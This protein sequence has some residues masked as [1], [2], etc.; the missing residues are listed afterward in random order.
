M[1]NKI[2]LLLV[3]VLLTGCNRIEGTSSYIRGANLTEDQK[4]IVKL[5]GEQIYIF[6]YQLKEEY[7]RL[8]TWWE[9]YKKGEYIGKQ[10]DMSSIINGKKGYIAEVRNN[11]SWQISH[12]TGDSVA[13]M[14]A[15]NLDVI[16]G[17]ETSGKAT[18]TLNDSVT[19]S[20][21]QEIVLM[22]LMMSEDGRMSVYDPHYYVENPEVIEEYD[23][24]YLLKCAFSNKGMRED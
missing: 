4:E 2:I 20:K 22:V 23:Y 12:K 21:D 18:S 17:H 3:I 14:I 6:E 24:I 5:I 15:D 11:K 9:L 10:L 13:R 7:A 19:I 16:D 8:D 1:R